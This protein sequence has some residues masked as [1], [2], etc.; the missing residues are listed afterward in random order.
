MAIYSCA[1]PNSRTIGKLSP[2]CF[3]QVFR[4]QN[5]NIWNPTHPPSCLFL[6]NSSCLCVPPNSCF[7]NI[8]CFQKWFATLL[9]KCL[10]YLFQLYLS[11][12]LIHKTINCWNCLLV[13]FNPGSLTTVWAAAS[14][15]AVT[16]W[17]KPGCSASVS[18]DAVTVWL[19]PDFCLQQRKSRNYTEHYY[20]KHYNLKHNFMKHNYM[21]HN[22]I[23][24]NYMK[25]THH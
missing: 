2:S 22:Y 13:F 17:L 11:P 15:D 9:N 4:C 14:L 21:K 6:H 23:E 25:H 5:N 16:V 18:L 3:I 10:L 1:E 7:S 19:K 8:T 20:V 24:H 12:K